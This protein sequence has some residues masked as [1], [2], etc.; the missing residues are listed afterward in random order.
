MLSIRGILLIL[1]CAFVPMMDAFIAGVALPGIRRDFGIEQGSA[2]LSLVLVGYLAGFGSLLIVGGRVGDRYGRRRILWAAVSGFLIASAACGAAPTFWV[3]VAGRIV[4]G[5]TAGF[6]MP[7][8]LGLITTHAGQRRERAIS[9]YSSMSGI[10]ALIGLIGG[11]ALLDVIDGSGAWRWLFLVNIPLGIVALALLPR[12]VPRT[13]PNTGQYVDWRGGALLSLTV[14]GFLLTASLATSLG[15]AVLVLAAV[16]VLAG[17]AWVLHLRRCART[18]TA[19]VVPKG[20]FDNPHLRW[21][22][23]LML[24]F[25]AG[26]GGFLYALPQTLQEGL[27]QSP[28]LAGVVTAPMALG[29]FVS[30]FAVPRLRD[31]LGITTIAL[32]A[33]IQAAGLAAMAGGVTTS[34]TPLMCLA[35]LLI[36]IGQG[37][38]LGA[39]N[40]HMLSLV[41]AELAGMGGGVLLT[42]QQVSIA[43][44]TAVL[45]TVFGVLVQSSG[46]RTAMATVL[47]VQI[48]LAGL[49]IGAGLRSAAAVR[50]GRL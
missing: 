14:L 1:A 20:M 48:L 28:L 35:L 40:A 4:Q 10:S 44:G 16:T 37:I 22:L 8:V 9:W 27:G 45:G 31:R 32:G 7:Q 47:G 25:F 6:V 24:P 33:G 23:A 39:M 21:A 50:V 2:L 11:S 34:T 5:A 41:P 46:H 38:T 42:A 15:P 49:V 29:F 13:E 18:N 43:T 3:L 19:A 36:G 17:R 30:S 26:A 12:L